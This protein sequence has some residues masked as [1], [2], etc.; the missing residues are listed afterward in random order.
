[1]HALV[2]EDQDLIASLIEDEL[3]ELG[4]TSFD[5][6]AREKEA[7]RAAEERCPDLI[8][9]D[10]RIAD[11]SGVLAVQEICANQVIPVVFIVGN[12]HEVVPPVPFAA[13]IG[14]PFAISALHDAIDKA[15]V[16]ARRHAR[17]WGTAAPDQFT[18]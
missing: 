1:M 11:G 6:V 7:V 17:S 15:L 18:I 2:I 9:A 4:Y 5:V 10:D 16:L 14:K 13:V 12:P 8:T 3:R